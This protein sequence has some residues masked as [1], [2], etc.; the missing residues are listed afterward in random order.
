[1]FNRYLYESMIDF[2]WSVIVHALQRLLLSN[3][4]L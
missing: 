3:K 1:M 4:S 2:A